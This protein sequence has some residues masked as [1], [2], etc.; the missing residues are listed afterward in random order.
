MKAHKDYI[1]ENILREYVQEEVTWYN[2]Y[3]RTYSPHSISR[4]THT[5]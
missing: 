4:Y 2:S 3:L 5:Q 1:G